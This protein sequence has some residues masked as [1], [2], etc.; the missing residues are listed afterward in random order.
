MKKADTTPAV[1]FENLDAVRRPV[2]DSVYD[3]AL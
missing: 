1:R 3:G 2:P